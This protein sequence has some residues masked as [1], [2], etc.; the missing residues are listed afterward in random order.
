[1]SSQVCL[2][3]KNLR[4]SML[5]QRCALS[6]NEAAQMSRDI[7]KKVADYIKKQS[8][9]KLVMLFASYN[10]EPD[11]DIL[12]NMLKGF[13]ND[14]GEQGSEI[15]IA[16]PKVS[17]N[18]KDMEFFIVDD[19]SK[20]CAGYMGIR[21]PK[22]SADAMADISE[23]GLIQDIYDTIYVIVPGL[24]FDKSGHR[25]GYGG[26]FYDRYSSRIK[27]NK[28]LRDSVVFIGICYDFQMVSKGTIEHDAHD[29]R[30]DIV[31]TDMETVNV[32][33]K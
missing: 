2:D 1:M 31:I 15:S 21:E 11:T 23:T 27:R 4:K 22:Y 10:K 32:N 33:E 3:K 13:H 12:Y 25:A 9:S 30:C 14:N 24:A 26:G 17:D 8:G 29:M 28:E 5:N 6:D 16:Y 19:I 20:L 18:K 7:A